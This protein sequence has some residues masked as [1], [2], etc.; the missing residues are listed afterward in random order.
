MK[1]A[2]DD[3]I[4]PVFVALCL[5]S[6]AVR[7]L[8]IP[9]DGAVVNGFTHDS[10]YIS[11]VAERVRD[12]QGFT[13][14]AHWLLFLNPPQ[15][16]MP[17]HNAN[18]GYPAINAAIS[19][20][21][22]TDVVFAGLL[23]SALSS[24]LLASVVFALVGRFGGDRRFSACCAVA[25]VLFPPIWRISFALAPDALAT[26]LGLG[27]LAAATR[28][29]SAWGW[30]A[31]GVVFGAAWLARSTSLLMV[32]GLLWWVIRTRTRREAVAA[33]LVFGVG[34]LLIAAPW[35]VHTW[36]TWGSALR[37]DAGY[38]W[39]QDYY[40][41]PFGGDVSKYW[42]SLTPPPSLGQVLSN[43]PAGFVWHT[44]AGAPALAYLTAAG[45]SE[46]NR[47]AAA[48]LMGLV[49]LA[50]AQ[51]YQLW[52]RPDI[53]GGLLIVAATAA[54]LLER[55]HS[56]EIRYFSVA[57][58]LLVLWILRPLAAYFRSPAG[59][60]SSM[61]R[62]ASAAGCA[63]YALV[64]LVTQDRRITMEMM[65][66]SPELS[67][68]RA[69]AHEVADEFPN[70]P[71]IVTDQP[72]LYTY[73]TKHAAL[74]PPNADKAEL[75]NFMTRYSARLL[76]LPTDSIDYYYP[77]FQDELSPDIEVFGHPGS[78]TLLRRATAP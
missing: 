35:L 61:L 16:P 41:R 63:I 7:A 13:N 50:T 17:F 30:L 21:F 32:P 60:R 1:W 62:T 73:Y 37:S 8:S 26:A 53:Q 12:G 10:G 24:V 33:M 57:T 43:D 34:A 76:L 23:V 47:F 14:P 49:A 31:S 67:S 44:L 48:L 29:R 22:R 75:L 15:L 46:W 9:A 19:A 51:S 68:Y 74:S 54:S 66:P 70:E 45:L 5:V 4:G 38:Y 78:Y 20:A 58:V 18:P 28:A 56:F 40:A 11:T 36:Q 64:F 59:T 42:R 69:V 71:A 6:A 52:R 2:T 25:V 65:Q 55:A 3:G 77:R 27:T 72:Y 39:L